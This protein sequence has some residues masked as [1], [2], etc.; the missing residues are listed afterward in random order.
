MAGLELA[1]SVRVLGSGKPRFR[2]AEREYRKQRLGFGFSILERIPSRAEQPTSLA[3]WKRA[4][5]PPRNDAPDHARSTHSGSFLLRGR[6][7]TGYWCC[8][9]PES[10]RT[11]THLP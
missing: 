2:I 4:Q 6:T 11:Q 9:F 10:V 7:C 5:L 3:C 1:R 8:R